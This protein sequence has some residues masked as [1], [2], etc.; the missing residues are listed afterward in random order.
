MTTKNELIAELAARG[1]NLTA[2]Q[3]KKTTKAG[4]QELLDSLNEKKA[5]KH[6]AQIAMLAA[7]LT[8][9]E[10]HVV[11]AMC[12][13]GMDVNGGE[14]VDAILEDNM[15]YSDEKGIAQRTGLKAKSVKGVLGSLTKRG[16]VSA[17]ERPNGQPGVD[18]VLNDDAIRVAFELMAD[19]WEANVV[20]MNP[21]H[22]GIQSPKK[23]APKLEVVE[24]GKKEKPAKKK[25][26]AKGPR[27]LKPH[28]FCE[29]VDKPE[30]ITA[31]QEG[32]KK[33]K[34]FEALWDGATI[35]ELMEATEWSRTT[36]QSA[37]GYDVKN[38]GFGVE[39]RDDQKYYILKPAGLKRLPV[40][41]KGQSRA[42]A[43]VAACK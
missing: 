43:L 5:E 26:A 38:S 15:T 7:D 31:V 9:M 23:P 18:Q 41:T 11:V 35:E 6:D 17:S 2:S 37:F 25:P 13:E 20:D 4:L 28:R 14:T 33:H 39:R 8:N 34:L 24:G 29:P 40:T 12:N 1:H 21:K 27:V 19:G 42:D 22:P 36:V 10:K 16:L 3:V 30:N 32:S